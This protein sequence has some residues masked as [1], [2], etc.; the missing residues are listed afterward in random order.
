MMSRLKD[1]GFSPYGGLSLGIAQLLTPGYTITIGEETI[2]VPEQSGGGFGIMPEVGIAIGGC[3]MSA[4][5]LVPVKYTIENVVTDK[6]VGILN[7]NLGYRYN[8]G[9]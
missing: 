3:Q 2:V 4:S 9:F 1:Q 8:F 6:S 5:Y 7:I